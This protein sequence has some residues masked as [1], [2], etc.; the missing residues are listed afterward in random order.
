MYL[1]ES[2]CDFVYGESCNKCGIIPLMRGRNQMLLFMVKQ[3][4]FSNHCQL[5]G[6]NSRKGHQGKGQIALQCDL[7]ELN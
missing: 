5:S 7:R 2:V 3:R 4:A 6:E 1:I